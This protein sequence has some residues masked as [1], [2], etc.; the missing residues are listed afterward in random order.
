MRFYT[1]NVLGGIAD[2]NIDRKARHRLF[3]LVAY[4]LNA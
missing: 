3:P 1:F 4:C 2:N